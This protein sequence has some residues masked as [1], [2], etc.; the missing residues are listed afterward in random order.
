MRTLSSRWVCHEQDVFSTCSRRVRMKHGTFAALKD[1]LIIRR[2]EKGAA[3]VMERM[4][5]FD[6]LL[7]T[8]KRA[9][10]LPLLKTTTQS[11]CFAIY[12]RFDETTRGSS[13]ASP[14][15]RNPQEESTAFGSEYDETTATLPPTPNQRNLFF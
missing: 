13:H 10:N 1:A 5:N 3:G 12:Y 9:R 14:Q 15:N 8:N 6:Q 4:A 11:A 7:C 2:K